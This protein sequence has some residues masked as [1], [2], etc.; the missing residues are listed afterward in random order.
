[1]NIQNL[2]LI[3][4]A[5]LN[6]F[7]ALVIILRNSKSRINWSFGLLLF[8]VV[9]W[10]LTLAFSNSINDYVAVLF[11]SRATYYFSTIIAVFL[12]YFSLVFPYQ[13][14][15]NKKQ[16]I[17]I[18]LPLIMILLILIKGNLLITGVIDKEWGYDVEFDS[19]WYILYSVYFFSFMIWSFINIWNKLKSATGHFQFQLRSILIGSLIAVGFGILFNLILPY[20]GIW[21]L[22]WLGPYFT[23]TVL[24][25][26][27][28]LIFYKP[29]A[30]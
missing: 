14:H 24:F 9:G 3:I 15:L 23:I 19:L 12:V 10:C 11:W 26:I 16:K 21:S 28:Y 25:I 1:M 4:I 2:I 20:F 6:F 13:S 29:K 18:S 5:V 22:N 30:D 7:V 8:S 27:T 17:F